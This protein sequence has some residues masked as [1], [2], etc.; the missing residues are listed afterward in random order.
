LNLIYIMGPSGA[1]KDSLLNSLHQEMASLGKALPLIMAQRT[2]TRSHHQSNENHEAVDEASFES[3]LQS[4][5]F[6]LNWFA[7]GLHYGIRHEQ[8]APMSK[9]SWVMVNGSRAY[10]EQAKLRFPGLTVLHITA[11]VDVLRS[12]LLA[13][14]R[15]NEKDIEA[16]LSRSQSLESNPQDL[17]VINDGRLEDS[18]TKLKDLLQER[19]GIAFNSNS[20]Q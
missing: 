2:I 4:N 6:A 14:G 7:N 9:G 11:P 1:G 12:R 16:R 5:A 3:L 17:Y 18:L 15:E 8:L 10:L 20:N 13:R 19:T